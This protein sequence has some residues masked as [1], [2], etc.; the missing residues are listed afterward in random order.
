MHGRRTRRAPDG[1]A[2]QQGALAFHFLFQAA[3]VE[4]GV[5]GG[6]QVR[7]QVEGLAVAA[8]G[9]EQ[10]HGV[11][12]REPSQPRRRI[13]ARE[14]LQHVDGRGRIAARKCARGVQ[15]GAFVLQPCATCGDEFAQFGVSCGAVKRLGQRQRRVERDRVVHARERLQTLDGHIASADAVIDRAA[16]EDDLW[17]LWR[18]GEGARDGA[19]GTTQQAHAQRR[20]RHAHPRGQHARLLLHPAFGHLQCLREILLREQVLHFARGVGGRHGWGVP[21]SGACRQSQ[22]PCFW[23]K[24][25]D[26]RRISCTRSNSSSHACMVAAASSAG[27]TAPGM[28]HAGPSC[29]AAIAR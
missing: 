29:R 28:G 19:V 8:G 4:A 3:H 15:D 13:G 1:A 23:R 20:A 25:P 26:S 22:S 21:Q 7:G 11:E 10:A 2:R 27:S 18:H 5:G 14:L 24:R 6:V 17:I 9:V 16:E 12:A